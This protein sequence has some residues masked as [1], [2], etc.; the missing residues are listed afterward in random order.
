[1]RLPAGFLYKLVRSA[2]PVD[3]TPAELDEFL[4]F[5]NAW[6]HSPRRKRRHPALPD[7]AAIEA[8]RTNG[9]A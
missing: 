7:L 6:V 4:D 8:L 9:P 2:K 1:M 3:L 5:A